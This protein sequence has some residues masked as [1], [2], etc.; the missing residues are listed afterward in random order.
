MHWHGTT[1]DHWTRA[2]T[3]VIENWKWHKQ[4]NE[5]NGDGSADIMIYW[6]VKVKLSYMQNDPANRSL[7][8]PDDSKQTS[9]QCHQCSSSCYTGT[10]MLI[11]CRRL[12][13]SW[14]KQRALQLETGLHLEDRHTPQQIGLQ[15]GSADSSQICKAA[16]WWVTLLPSAKTSNLFSVDTDKCHEASTERQHQLFWRGR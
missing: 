3:M 16:H 5:L 11:D 4:K 9:G 15:S 14:C 1:S 6:M 13:L 7:C 2:V 10:Y 8:S 12:Q